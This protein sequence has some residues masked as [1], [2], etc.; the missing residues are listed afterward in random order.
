MKNKIK[1]FLTDPLNWNIAAAVLGIVCANIFLIEGKAL[2][3]II[4]AIVAGADVALAYL[5]AKNRRK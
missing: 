2:L 5:E 4:W 3:A 1:K